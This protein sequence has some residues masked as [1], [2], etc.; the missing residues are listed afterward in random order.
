MRL[1]EPKIKAAILHPEEEVRVAAV[2]YFSGSLSRDETIM[3]VVIKAVEMYGRHQ[4]FRILRAAEHLAQTPATVEWLVREL[5]RGYDLA[6]L[7]EDNY[8]FAVALVLFHARPEVL[9]QR[10]GFIIALPMFPDELRGPLDERLDMF[11][12]DWDQGWAALEALGQDTMRRGGFTQNDVR[13]AHRIIGSLARHR[14]TKADYVLSLLHRPGS[15]ARKERLSWLEPLIVNLAGAMR[16]EA[17]VLLL[18]RRLN[19]KDL[20]VEHESITALVRIST[21]AVVRAI[22]HRWRVAETGFRAA[23]A[24]VLESIHTDL[25]VGFCQ[26]FLLAEQDAETKLLLAHAL[27]S[28]FAEE[29]VEPVRQ[30]VLGHDDELTPDGLDIRYRLVVTCSIMGMSFPEYKKWREDAVADNWG[31]GDYRP[32]RL[33]DSFRPDQPGADRSRNGKRYPWMQ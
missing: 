4:A 19:A 1:L 16:L 30:L 27:L 10:K 5:R 26:R 11:S 33:A 22:A 18:L 7:D 31:L 32:P 25:C 24:D 2:S 9:L 28:Q 3:F 17:G 21:D 29:G 6:D 8:R 13:Y 12:W 14:T 15:A 20:G 23:A